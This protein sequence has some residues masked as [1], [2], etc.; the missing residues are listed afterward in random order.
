M[1]RHSVVSVFDAR[2]RALRRVAV[3]LSVFAIA[4]LALVASPQLPFAAAQGATPAAP[5]S[6]A[7][8]LKIEVLGKGLPDA[9]PGHTLMLVR[10]TF[11]P[12]GFVGLHQH[13]GALVLAIESGELNYTLKEGSAQILHPA[14][15]GTPGPTEELKPGVETT[16]KAGDAL[17]EQGVIHSARN[18]GTVPTVVLVSGLIETGH[19]FSEFMT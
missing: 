18:V 12:G 8:G 5:A 7:K 9:G 14:V 3:M 1:Q 19:P 17:F 11:A 13:P 6:N 4:L 10:L 2:G 15:D 16:L